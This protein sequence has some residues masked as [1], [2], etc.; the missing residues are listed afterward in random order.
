MKRTQEVC[1]EPNTKEPPPIKRQKASH[2]CW[3]P[4]PDKDKWATYL[5]LCPNKFLD[6]CHQINYR[7]VSLLEVCKFFWINRK[8]NEVLAWSKYYQLWQD[9][10]ESFILLQICEKSIGKNPGLFIMLI[11][12]FLKNNIMQK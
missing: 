5:A 9:F 10:F 1:D 2:F 7:T 8:N 6:Q 11:N 4:S 12:S 3:P